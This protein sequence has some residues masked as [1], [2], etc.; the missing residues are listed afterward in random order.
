MN[1]NTCHMAEQFIK[2]AEER[3]HSVYR[4]DCARKR[5][6]GCIACNACGMNG[7]CV[8]KDDF[9]QLIP[10]LTKADMVVFS[11]PMY[12]FGM[13]AQM[14]AVIDRFYSINGRIKGRRKKAA[15]LMAFADTDMREADPMI[16]HYRTLL[17]YLGWDDAGMV[18]APGMWT[19]GSVNGTEYS[20]R[21]YQLG[22]SVS[23]D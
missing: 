23:D 9:Q 11:T 13:S 7:D 15:F 5:V 2:G 4:Y 1:G 8:L 3:G 12:Y 17:D 18:V 14:K 21:A 6:S 20:R 10:H 22:R 19:A 16:S